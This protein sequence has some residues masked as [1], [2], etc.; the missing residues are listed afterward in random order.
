MRR[1]AAIFI[2]GLLLTAFFIYFV[3]N[4]Q[5]FWLGPTVS[6][7]FPEEGVTLNNS[8]VLVKGRSRDISRL[9]LNG[10]PIYTDEKGN[11]EEE[12]IL[13]S[14]L[15]IIELKADGRFGRKLFEQRMVMVRMPE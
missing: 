6:I 2:F 4:F 12:L 3:F 11:F 13:F 9:E 5:G 7:D 1:F 8:R 10:R 14:G 15:N